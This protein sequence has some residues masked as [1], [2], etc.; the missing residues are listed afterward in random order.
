MKRFEY[1]HKRYTV[2]AKRKNRDE[3]WSEWTT[4]DAYEDAVRHAAHV[5]E[6]G[7]ESKI[8]DKG[9]NLNE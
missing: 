3:K 8:V 9:E 1:R 4:V 5:E 6:L 2:H 7:F